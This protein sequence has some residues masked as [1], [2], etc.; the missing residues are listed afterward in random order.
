[1]NFWPRGWY[2]KSLGLHLL[3]VEGPSDRF[4]EEGEDEVAFPALRRCEEIIPAVVVCNQPKT[5]NPDPVADSG[6]IPGGR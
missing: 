6:S 5:G 2:E 1:M 4:V 3:V